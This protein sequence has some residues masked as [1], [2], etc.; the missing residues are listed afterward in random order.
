MSGEKFKGERFEDLVASL[1]S[2]LSAQ[3][4]SNHLGDDLALL[5]AGHAVRD[6]NFN[7]SV[8]SDCRDSSLASS[9]AD[10][11]KRRQIIRQGV[12]QVDSK[13]IRK[14]SEL[15]AL[16]P[17]LPFCHT[18]EDI[19]KDQFL[20]VLV[21][22]SVYRRLTIYSKVIHRHSELS[23]FSPH[24]YQQEDADSLISKDNGKTEGS[25][26]QRHMEVQ[27][28]KFAMG[29]SQFSGAEKN[30]GNLRKLAKTCENSRKII[31]KFLQLMRFSFDSDTYIS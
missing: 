12:R 5:L 28:E 11:T 17:L 4:H 31:S 29:L 1:I 16:A 10:H 3:N 8:L 30:P 24:L 22:V 14:R 7:K 20:N 6:M 27:H 9:T 15:G 18:L 13:R 23:P 25:Q 21:G 19:S 26:L 2:R